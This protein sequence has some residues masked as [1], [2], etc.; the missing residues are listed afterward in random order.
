VRI[1]NPGE[2]THQ[3]NQVSPG[4]RHPAH[5]QCDQRLA[6][7][8]DGLSLGQRLTDDA[9]TPQR[10]PTTN[11]RVGLDCLPHPLNRELGVPSVGEH[12]KHDGARGRIE[13]LRDLAVEVRRNPITDVGLNQAFGPVARGGLRMKSLNRDDEGCHRLF[14]THSHAFEV[15]FEQLEVAELGGR[16]SGQRRFVF[17]S[18]CHAGVVCEPFEGDQFGIGE[19]AEQIGHRVAVGRIG[20]QV[21]LGGIV[22]A[23]APNSSA[24]GGVRAR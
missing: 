8:T 2:G 11:R 1:G 3:L 10:E 6:F 5:Q 17:E 9:P 20:Q 19:H 22:G 23:H 7:G 21:D 15:V 4:A 24:S 18:R 14:G 16:Q 13:Q 12:L